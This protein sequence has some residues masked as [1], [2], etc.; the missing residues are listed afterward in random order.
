MQALWQVRS[1]CSGLLA[2]ASREETFSKPKVQ[3]TDQKEPKGKGRSKGGRGKGKRGEVREVQDEEGDWDEEWF[4]EDNEEPET[5]EPGEKAMVV[6]A[7]PAKV[8]PVTVSP[9][10]G[11][12]SSAEGPAV[13]SVSHPLEFILSTTGLGLELKSSWLVDSGATVTL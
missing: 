8:D 1:Q 4:E 11:L 10:V 12:S 2:E 5:E 9:E 13:H 7:Q 3:P 6:K